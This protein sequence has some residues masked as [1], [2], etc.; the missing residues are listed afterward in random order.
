MPADL[1]IHS[2]LSD[3]TDTPEALVDLA[4]AARLKTI[5]LTDHDLVDGI[6][7]ARG[8][9]SEVGVE[10]IPA[11]EF[12]TDSPRAQVHILGYFIDY[13]DRELTAV[14]EEVQADRVNRIRKIVKKLQALGVK[15]GP[16]D[17]FNLAAKKAPGRPHVALALVKLGEV[18]SFK[19]A[20]NRYLEDGGPAYVPH[21]QLKPAEVI[22]L[23]RRT[24]GLAVFAHPR[25][26]NC[27]DLIPQLVADGLRGIEAYYTGYSPEETA[28]YVGLAKKQGLL[29]TGGSDYHGSGCGREIK[30]GEVTLPDEYVEALKNEH[31]RGN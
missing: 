28:R 25:I 6:D 14:L 21:Y 2:N 26:S 12:T 5:A 11:I 18:S 27:D 13:Q 23:I 8:R 3:G 16:E 22:K 4:A 17:V 10:V 9:G 1:H 29:V 7:R 20:F 24:G 19:E 30:L 31:L 15:I